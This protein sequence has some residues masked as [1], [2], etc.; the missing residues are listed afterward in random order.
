MTDARSN[1]IWLALAVEH[2]QASPSDINGPFEPTQRERI[3]LLAQ[4]FALHDA[5]AFAAFIQAHQPLNDPLHLDILT[6]A[7]LSSSLQKPKQEHD[8]QVRE[9]FD[10]IQAV[11]T[12]WN[13]VH[14]NLTKPATQQGNIPPKQPAWKERSQAGNR[15]F[16]YNSDG[17]AH[18]GMLPDFLQDLVNVGMDQQD[19]AVLHKS[20][21]AYIKLWERC[22]VLSR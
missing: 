21:E 3:K 22:L 16:D 1:E 19:L 17:M 15:V 4:G 11:R 13:R 18:Y 7:Y 10:A 20:A 9:W 12:I 5:A 8:A 14:P 6:A 2:H